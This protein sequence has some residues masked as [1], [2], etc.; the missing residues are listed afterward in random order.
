MSKNVTQL[1]PS[2]FYTPTAQYTNWR[3]IRSNSGPSSIHATISNSRKRERRGDISSSVYKVPD[4]IYLDD[5]EEILNKTNANTND[6]QLSM[7]NTTNNN[8][9]LSSIHSDDEQELYTNW[10]YIIRKNHE[11]Y[12][13]FTNPTQ[14]MGIS[15][16]LQCNNNVLPTYKVSGVYQ[17]PVAVQEHL[18]GLCN[19]SNSEQTNTDIY[20]NQGVFILKGIECVLSWL[21]IQNTLYIWD[22]SHCNEAIVYTH[23]DKDKNDTNTIY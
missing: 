15:N 3:D 22:T 19:N 7:Q 9:M 8:F 21:H 10:N 1:S 16:A 5:T 20:I 23:W 18:N 11:T 4:I 13:Y 17:W 2:N 6:I 14:L 12:Q